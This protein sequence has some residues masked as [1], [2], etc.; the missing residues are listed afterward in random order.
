VYSARWE[1]GEPELFSTSLGSVGERPLGAS[2]NL[3][4]VSKSG[5]LAI[6][7]E[8]RTVSNWIVTGT[9]A[10]MPIG[11]GAPREI[12]RDVS[13]ADWSPD[14]RELVVTRAQFAQ[15]R[16]RL[17]YPVG[18]VL[19]E[20]DKW[21]E[22]PRI[23][24]D[25]ST[26][27]VLE[28][29]GSG[30]NRGV[31]VFMSAAGKHTVATPEYSVVSG[32][33]WSPDGNELWFTASATGTSQVIYGVRLGGNV[34]EIGS[35]PASVNLEDAR[36]DG[37]TLMQSGALK[38][39]LI[40]KRIDTGEQRDLTWFD[41]PIL[42]DL[43][44]DGTTVVFEEAGE[45]GGPNY[46]AFLRHTDGSPA[47]RLGEGMPLR[48]SHDKQFVLLASPS[49]PL[50]DLTIVPIGPGESRSI[51]IPSSLEMIGSPRWL[52]DGSRLV[53]VAH[54][55]KHAAQSFT[56][57]LASREIATLTEEGV[58][59]TGVSPD[60]RWLVV[61]DAG[62]TRTL[63]SLADRRQAPINGL[64]P[65]DSIVA[66]AND[67]R[68]LFVSSPLAAGERD[69][70]RLDPATGRR[71]VLSTF[72][73]QDRSGIYTLNAPFV[74]ADGQTYVYQT[75]TYRSDLFVARGVR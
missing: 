6:L 55:G 17:E 56:Y 73:V 44:P 35:M 31:V 20:T 33:A 54:E 43:S 74:S 48:L 4:S 59:G 62:G 69:V 30:D 38:G 18:K 75:D 28:H 10:R 32:A 26:I 27:A 36:A 21:L 64:A 46:T 67:S 2:G 7:I 51:A 29:P 24:R 71:T 45:G 5:E 60:G 37:A 22:S 42:R 13:G 3:L 39:R 19:Y 63:W 65:K 66:W 52:P 11:G 70:A 23:S 72:A 40:A 25:G 9:L 50:N 53:F 34:R 8:P 16:W 41:Y 1:G 49:K 12:L 57:S 61:N 68:T 58:Y 47:V 15:N 14:G